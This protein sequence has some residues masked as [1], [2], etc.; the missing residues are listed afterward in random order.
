MSNLLKPGFQSF[1]S[2][3]NSPFIVDYSKKQIGEAKIIRS[4]EET[5][6]ES[7]EEEVPGA[8]E[9]VLN[10]ALDKAKLVRD[11]AILKASQIIA[12]AQADAEAIKQ[13]AYEEGYNQGLSD[14]NMEAMKRAD[15]YLVNIQQEQDKIIEAEREKMIASL[16]QSANNLIDF[17]CKIIEKITGVLIEEYKPVML[18]M[19]NNALADADTSKYYIIKVSDD[20]YTYVSDNSDRLVGAANPGIKIEVFGDSALRHDQCVIETEN[21]LIDLSLDVQMKNLVLAMKMLSD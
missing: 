15:E 18:H 19:I 20:N 17:S 7:V 11:D 21:G 12:D 13:Q 8:N 1:S 9:A 2:N 10:D 14:G 5:K 6:E 16:D 4:I 3:T